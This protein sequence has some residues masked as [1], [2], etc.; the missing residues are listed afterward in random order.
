MDQTPLL[1]RA[2]A[3]AQALSLSRTVIYNLIASGELASVKVGRARRIPREALA[4][5]I[6]R[7]LAEGTDA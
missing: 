7:R 5:F 2:E 3:C 4:E 1:L 6:E